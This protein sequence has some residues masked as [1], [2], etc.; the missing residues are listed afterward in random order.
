M[1]VKNANGNAC[2]LIS[3]AA[4]EFFAS[5]LAPTVVSGACKKLIS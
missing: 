5:T 4:L 2:C 1:L 3:R